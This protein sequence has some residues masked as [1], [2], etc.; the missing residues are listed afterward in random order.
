MPDAAVQGALFTNARTP[1]S[2][3]TSFEIV[4]SLFLKVLSK[5]DP[6]TCMLYVTSRVEYEVNHLSYNKFI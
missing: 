6:D 2:N 3:T 4:V 1:N 5:S